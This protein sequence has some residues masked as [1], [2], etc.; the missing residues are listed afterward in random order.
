MAARFDITGIS[1]DGLIEIHSALVPLTET[2]RLMDQFGAR[3]E[4]AMRGILY[5]EGESIMSGAKKQVPVETGTLRNSGFVEL[6]EESSG[7]LSVTIGFGGAAAPYALRQHEDLTFHHKEG[8]A[9]F[10]ALP[11]YAA[12]P[13]MDGRFA[14]ELKTELGL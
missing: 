12:K 8:N 4:H 2:E 5:R 7:T 13:T 6:P 3:A 14:A 9:K 10:L 11:F 1:K